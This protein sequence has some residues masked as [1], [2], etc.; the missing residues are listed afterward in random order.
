MMFILI[1]DKCFYLNKQFSRVND[2]NCHH[3]KYGCP[4]SPY[5]SSKSFECKSL[6]VEKANAFFVSLRR[7]EAVFT[8]TD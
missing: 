5:M 6:Y 7:T 3:F 2:Y 1:S 8:I 4:I